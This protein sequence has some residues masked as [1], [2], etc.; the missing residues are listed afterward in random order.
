MSDLYSELL[1][2]KESTAKDGIMKYGLIVLTALAVLAGIFVNPLI[3]L[4]AV[5]L[6]IACYF[7]IPKTD[8][9]YEYLFINGDFD[10]DMIMSKTK[11]KK[12]K[13]F[14]LSES[15]LAAPLDSHRMD[16]YNG[17]QN[18]KVLDFS[19]GNPEHK[20][21]GVITRLDGNLC[22]IILEPDEALAQAM[23]NSAPSKVFLD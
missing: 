2:K 6:G 9:E 12:V 1:V 11:R 8:V 16:Y 14:K 21:F 7:V 10:I 23:K 4:A 20:R 3:L 15:D 17:N 5:V 22:K 18:M 19:S 13:S